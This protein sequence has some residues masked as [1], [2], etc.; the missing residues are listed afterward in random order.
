MV[1]LHKEEDWTEWEYYIRKRTGQN[2]SITLVRGLDR[3]GVLHK[4][5]DWTVWEY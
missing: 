2:G 3:M 1:V 5:E 4:K